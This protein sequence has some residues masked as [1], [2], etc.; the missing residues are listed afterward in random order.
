MA[1]GVVPF[2][3]TFVDDKVTPLVV[4]KGDQKTVSIVPLVSVRVC[5][6]ILV[7]CD[8]RPRHIYILSG[9]LLE[10]VEELGAYPVLSAIVYWETPSVD[11]SKRL[12]ASRA[13]LISVLV[14]G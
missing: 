14:H 7:D 8:R 6:V 11:E 10:V 5:S 3:L 12:G 4:S 1:D 2:Q 9:E 13:C